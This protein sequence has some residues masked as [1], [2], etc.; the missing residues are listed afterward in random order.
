[1]FFEEESVKRIGDHIIGLYGAKVQ[2]V[3]KN[4]QEPEVDLE[5]KT[6]SGAVYIHTSRPG[7]AHP[8]GYEN[9]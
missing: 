1:M 5:R 9:R 7:K 8:K 3:S 4:A 2:A 6:D